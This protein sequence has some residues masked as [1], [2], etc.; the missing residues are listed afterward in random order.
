MNCID[1]TGHDGIPFTVTLFSTD[2]IVNAIDKIGSYFGADN[3]SDTIAPFFDT[4]STVLDVVAE[5]ELVFCTGVDVAG[6]VIGGTSGAVIT[7]GAAPISGPIG[8]AIGYKAA[9]FGT[10]SLQGA[11][12]ALGVASTASTTMSDILTGD[13]SFSTGFEM[14]SSGKYGSV[15][16]NATLGK[17]TYLSAGITLAG[18]IGGRNAPS[19]L[20][21]Q[22]LAVLNDLGFVSNPKTG[23]VISTW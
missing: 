1:P 7:P 21:F 15:T 22:T 20:G 2:M 16:F 11:A 13:T 9:E 17:D 18:Y 4:A 5:A 12:L 23:Y 6:V 3:L 10:R 19:A 14:A 8:E